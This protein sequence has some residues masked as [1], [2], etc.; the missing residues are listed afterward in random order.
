MVNCPLRESCSDLRNPG[1]SASASVPEFENNQFVATSRCRGSVVQQSHSRTRI[2]ASTASSTLRIP[3]LCDR[4]TSHRHTK[5][6][7]TIK[8]TIT[9]HVF[10]YRLFVAVIAFVAQ[11]AICKHKRQYMLTAFIRPR[12]LH[13][14]SVSCCSPV[15]PK[16]LLTQLSILR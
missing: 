2:V 12:N 7:N 14:R 4:C 16:M 3:M 10:G 13:G 1:A 11:V 8:R 9:G 15:R 5:R 6:H